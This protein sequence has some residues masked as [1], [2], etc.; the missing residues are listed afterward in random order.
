MG[1]ARLYRTRPLAP[2]D[3]PALQRLFEGARDYFEIATGAGPAPDEAARAF[4]A[5]PP[6]KSVND[7][8]TI[9]VFSGGTLIGVI[10]TITDWPADRVWT[11]GMLLLDPEHRGRGV[12]TEVLGAFERW[13][14]AEGAT[15]LRTAVVARH[16]AGIRFLTRQ[17]YDRVADGPGPAAP[18]AYFEKT[19]EP[20]RA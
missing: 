8:R 13:A 16:E 12:G 15:S 20:A 6:T 14:A 2:P 11:M 4:V 17:R 9:G 19:L 7:K 5:G 18:I 10:D 3:L 1:P